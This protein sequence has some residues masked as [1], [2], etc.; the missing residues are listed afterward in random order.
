MIADDCMTTKVVY[1]T[2]VLK[3]GD[4][5]WL[6][7]M[8]LEEEGAVP[9][10]IGRGM[11]HTIDRSSMKVEYVEIETNKWKTLILMP[12]NVVLSGEATE[13]QLRAVKLEGSTLYTFEKVDI[14]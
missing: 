8:M 10:Y 12:D 13:Q 1:N 9:F 11:I 3:K 4:V 7:E 5:L 2:E 14:K 6:Y